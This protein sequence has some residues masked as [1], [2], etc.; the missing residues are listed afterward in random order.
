MG[1]DLRLLAVGPFH[2]SLLQTELLDY[3]A[4]C[5]KNVPEGATIVITAYVAPSTHLSDEVLDA[6]N[7]GSTDFHLHYM[8]EPSIDTATYLRNLSE[9]GAVPGDV[10]RAANLVE[11]GFKF[12]ILPDF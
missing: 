10:E 1:A 7:V 9:V 4:Q 11:R 5:Y 8:I 2:K 3:P 6:F 12:I